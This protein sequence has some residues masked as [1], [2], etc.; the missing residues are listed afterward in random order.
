MSKPLFTVRVEVVHRV[1][2]ENGTKVCRRPRPGAPRRRNSEPRLIGEIL[3]EMFGRYKVRLKV[4]R[5][6]ALHKHP[7]RRAGG[8]MA[9]A[10]AG[11]PRR[12]WV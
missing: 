11:G 7:G 6:K 9:A 3:A 10:A 1:E 4:T 12:R 8:R 2:A 5:S